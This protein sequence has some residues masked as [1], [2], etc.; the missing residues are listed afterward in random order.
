MCVY[1]R[2]EFEVSSINLTILDRWEGDG[3]NFTPPTPKQTPKKANQIRVNILIHV[4]SMTEV[5][6]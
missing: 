5:K 6:L 4:F 3:G 1:L 2:A